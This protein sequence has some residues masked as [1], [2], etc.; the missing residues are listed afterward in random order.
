MRFLNNE[1][2]RLAY[3]DDRA[4]LAPLLLVHGCGLD[5]CSLENIARHFADSRRVISVDLR[6]HG[7]SDAPRQEY[8][9][10]GYAADLA[11][12]CQHLSLEQ[13]VAVG[14]SMGGNI[15]LEFASRHSKLVSAVVMLD[16]VVL[17][18]REMLQALP[19][20]LGEM[21][22]SPQYLDAY[23]QA[24][25]GMCLA[26]DARSFAFIET[27]QARQHVLAP[28]LLNHTVNYDGSAA[29]AACHVPV[30]YIHSFM[31]F[32]DLERFRS[33]TPHLVHAQTLGSGHFSPLEVP[34]QLN[35]MIAQFLDLQGRVQ[36]H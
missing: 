12:L 26:S 23:K 15:A 1:G 11:A 35:A 14:H 4:Q 34:N 36:N 6:G 27:V 30:A 29:A 22:A 33:L 13:V 19:P 7:E 9:M 20:N 17:P 21:L 24:L 32:V 18:S 25:R 3:E 31:P 28:S 2:V 16:S 8:T 10:P 5:H